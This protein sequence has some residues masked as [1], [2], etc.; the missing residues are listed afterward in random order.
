MS[1]LVKNIK[2][3]ANRYENSKRSNQPV[4]EEANLNSYKKE[5]NVPEKRN[6][7]S[8][9]TQKQ[10]GNAARGKSIAEKLGFINFNEEELDTPSFMRKD[11]NSDEKS[12]QP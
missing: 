6:E 12:T 7:E 1:S 8:A 5:E 3:A 11:K 4:N 2:E 9:Q 10:A